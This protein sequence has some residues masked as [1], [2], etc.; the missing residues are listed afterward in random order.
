MNLEISIIIPTLNESSN[1]G[2]LISHLLTNLSGN[3]EI[4]VVDGGS[5]DNTIE[6]AS[7]LGAKVFHSKPSRAVQMNVGVKNAQ[8]S[9]Y[10][11]VHADT[12]PPED[13]LEDF[14]KVLE[15]GFEAACFRSAY[16]SDSIMLKINAFFTRFHWLVSRG[17]DQSLFITK[18]KFYDMCCFDELM[19]IM[20]EYPLI[21]K[22][23]DEKS[24]KIIPKNILISTRK[25]NDRGWLKVNRANFK[26]FKMYKSGVDS[27]KIKETYYNLLKA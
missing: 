8:Y 4:I 27:R 17:G 26:V 22:L 19:E 16:D 5:T 15:E 13:F 23:M 6:I 18:R 12:L 2:R 24:L 20:E 3:F 9:N 11:F 14:Q 1:I 21:K 25:Y 10:Y 7:E